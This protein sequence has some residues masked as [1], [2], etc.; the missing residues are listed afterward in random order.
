MLRFS[1]AKYFVASRAPASMSAISIDSTGTRDRRGRDS[2]AEAEH[3]DV[4]RGRVDQH[5]Q[6][7]QE[8]LV[9]HV[10]RVGRGVGLA[11]RAVEP[12]A[13]LPVDRE[14]RGDPV[15]VEEDLGALLRPRSAARSRRSRRRSRLPGPEGSAA[16]PAG[17]RGGERRGRRGEPGACPE[18]GG[19]GEGEDPPIAAA[20]AATVSVARKPNHGTN[21]NP[22]RKAPPTVP[23]VFQ[24][25]TRP[26]P[27]PIRPDRRSPRS[28]AGN[29]TPKGSRAAAAPAP[30]PESAA[31]Q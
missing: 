29:A 16:R 28:P 6:M 27:R 23:T 22:P 31:L 19:D 15:F 26:T 8:E 13:P 10:A 3:E 9:G 14:R 5:R 4:A 7:A 17:Q 11:V 1:W 30:S 18:R 12:V 2:R 25:I 20:A 24:A 21:T